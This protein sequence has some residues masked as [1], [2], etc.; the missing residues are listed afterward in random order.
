MLCRLEFRRNSRGRH[1]ACTSLSLSPGS[2]EYRVPSDVPEPSPSLCPFLVLPSSRR[3]SLSRVY[4]EFK[5]RA[6]KSAGTSGGRAIRAHS[7]ATYLELGERLIG[8]RPRY[9]RCAQVENYR[10]YSVAQISQTTSTIAAF[11]RS[12]SSISNL[13]K[14]GYP[15]KNLFL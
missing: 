15:I 1:A 4:R 12:L 10:R 7:S 5:A 8:E 11:Q 14:F 13:R 9:E 2:R 6:G 3:T